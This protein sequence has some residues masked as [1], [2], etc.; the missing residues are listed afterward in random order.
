MDAKTQTSLESRRKVENKDRKLSDY[1]LIRVI[2]TGTFGRVFCA[3]YKGKSYA[4]KVL[5]K[6][7]IIKLDQV[8]NIKNEKN[9]LASI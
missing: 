7:K 6:Q 3:M 1:Q 9:I 5:K 8:S 2:G 4:V